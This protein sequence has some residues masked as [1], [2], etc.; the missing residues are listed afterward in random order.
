MEIETR[1]PGR[2]R[3]RARG[4]ARLRRV[5]RSA[6][7][8]RQEKRRRAHV[9]QRYDGDVDR[10][11][12]RRP[13]RER[14][15]RRCATASE[16]R[17]AREPDARERH[18]VARRR[19]R[20]LRGVR[21]AQRLAT[22]AHRRTDGLL[23]L[24]FAFAAAFFYRGIWDRFFVDSVHVAPGAAH[25]VGTLAY[26]AVAYAV[27]LALGAALAT[28][29]KT[30]AARHRE[31]R[32]RR[33]RRLREE[34]RDRMGDRLRRPVFSAARRNP[35]R[36]ARFATGATHRTPERRRGR[37]AARVDPD[38]VRPFGDGLFAL[39]RS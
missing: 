2:C 14:S 25:V 29:A 18:R 37:A 17:F 22:R 10:R 36:F 1:R 30:A 19:H 38:P 35:A 28:V 3:R 33:G 23:A 13:H 12:G 21:Y 6:S 34:R 26:A 32:T 31:S 5:S 24:A 20:H 11:R 4:R 7:R 27:V 16:R 8:G 39:H 15:S 9:L